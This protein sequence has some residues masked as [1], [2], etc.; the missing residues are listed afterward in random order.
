[1]GLSLKERIALNVL[2]TVGSLL[3]QNGYQLAISRALAKTNPSHLSGEI[4]QLS[5]TDVADASI[6]TDEWKQAFAI[7]VYVIPTEDDTVPVDSYNNDID[8]SLY[9]A[10]MADPHR[11]GLALDTIIEPTLYFPP[12]EGE[13]SGITFMFQV[14]YRHAIDKP[15]VSLS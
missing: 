13:F 1:M 7:V 5:P 2:S 14:R 6:G 11:G 10:L 3:T 12:V 9:T 4:F 15:Y 8:A